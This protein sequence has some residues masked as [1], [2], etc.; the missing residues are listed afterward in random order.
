[1][2]SHRSHISH[3]I[4]VCLGLIL[5]LGIGWYIGMKYRPMASPDGSVD[6]Q[7]PLGQAF[8]PPEEHVATLRVS[9][10]NVDYSVSQWCEG[11]IQHPGS[12]APYCI[13]KNKLTISYLQAVNQK[14]IVTDLDIRDTSSP[15]DS[16]IL[17]NAFLVAQSSTRATILISYAAD[18]C[19]TKGDC[20]PDAPTNFVTYAYV[21][22]SDSP[23]F[24]ALVHYPPSGTAVWN[25]AGTKSVFIPN[26]CG[27]GGCSLQPLVG[28]DLEKDS[29]SN[30]TDVSAVGSDDPNADASDPTGQPLP[31][32]ISVKWTDD[33]H[34]SAIIR[35]PD[36]T[37]KTVG[38]G[39]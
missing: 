38:G 22:G 35:Q 27:A 4:L 5:C 26:T 21:A 10:N 19:R 30:I 20:P 3:V 25:S 1:M 14:I 13:G 12:D 11:S 37:K 31:R 34:V 18:A 24:R 15:D 28:Y 39:F 23:A 9:W 33:S 6:E 8:E 17:I 32:W 29:A 7:Q 2:S 36:G 16:H